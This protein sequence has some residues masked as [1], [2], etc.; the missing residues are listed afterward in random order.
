MKPLTQKDLPALASLI[1]QSSHRR[2][3]V[4]NSHLSIVREGKFFADV[5]IE[6]GKALSTDI[7]SGFDMKSC[8]K[9]N[10]WPWEIV[11]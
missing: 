10:S 2:V 8:H 1:R 7:I 3:V 5:K 4:F 11:I 9:Q 6:N